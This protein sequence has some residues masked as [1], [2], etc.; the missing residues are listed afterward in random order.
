MTRTILGFDSWIGG[1][2]KYASLVPAL[3]R[4]D[5]RLLLVHIGSWGSDRGRPKQ[6]F[7]N[8]LEIRDIAWYDGQ[9]FE[10]ILRIEKPSA[11]LMLSNEVFAHRAFNRY[12]LAAGV[13]TLRL[14]HGLVGVQAVND[15]KLYQVSLISQTL[16]V[17]ARIPKALVKIWPCYIRALIRTGAGFGDWRRFV[18]DTVNLTRGAYIAHA[19]PDC[20]TT[21]AAV[22]TQAD[23]RHA[24]EKYGHPPEDVHVVGNPDISMFNLDEGRLGCALVDEN[25][26]INEIVYIDTGLIYTGMVFVD[27]NDYYAHLINTR[28]S[29]ARQ[30]KKMAI[31][32]HPHH[33]RTDFPARI[34]AAGI[35]VLSN[36]NFC[37][38][39][40][41]CAA[42]LVEPSTAALIPGLVGVPI[43]LIRYG[44]FAG[45]GYGKVMVEY[46]R[47]RYLDDPDQL[48]AILDE[49]AGS[50]DVIAVRHWIAENAGPLPADHMADRVAEIL[51][52]LSIG[53]SHDRP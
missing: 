48:Q 7:L 44:K 31:K 20:R 15:T 22:Y 17:L 8:D 26:A 49:E 30:G 47:A 41:R 24:V 2:G 51:D 33:F 35:E 12:S 9:N 34:E 36:T 38:R 5:M 46:P 37:E 25:P 23:V 52:A 53:A 50:L 29:L 45:Q 6:E 43:M 32:L 21:K 40:I 3:R 10:Q 14:Y 1:A 27:A 19:A 16:F 28:N 18:T 39:L 11:V 13:P 42:A 4:H